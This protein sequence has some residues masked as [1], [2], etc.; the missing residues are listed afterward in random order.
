MATPEHD[1][2]LSAAL[3]FL[4]R[5]WQLNH[6]LERLSSRMERSLGVTAQQRLAIRFIGRYPGVS[7]GTLASILKVDPGT[8]SAA[9]RRLEDKGVLSRHRDPR[10][11][12]RVSLGL[13]AKGRRLDRPTRGTAEAAVE[14]LLAELSNEEVGTAAR[15]L[16]RFVQ[17]L[18][19]AEPMHD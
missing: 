4:Q 18:N 12:R 5:L 3:D 19:E 11:Q 7:A 1:Y 17:L 15:V 9:L 16:D 14:R 13:T 6:A 8:V 2:P 10:D